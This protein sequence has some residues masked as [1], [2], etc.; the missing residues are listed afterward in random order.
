[1]TQE[2]L[3][4][5]QENNEDLDDEQVTKPKLRWLPLESNPDVLNKIIHENG[6]DPQ[7]S[8]T[9][10][11]GFDEESLS[12]IPKPVSAMIFLFPGTKN[13]QTFLEKEEAHLK[14]HEQNISPNLIYFKQTIS[15]ACG[16]MAL[17]HSLANNEHLVGSGLFTKIIEDTKNMSP[18]ERGEYLEGCPALAELHEYGAKHGQS[19]TPSL[20]ELFT[21]HFICFVQ[22]DDHLYELDG[23]RAFPINHGKSTDFVKDAAKIMR[24]F[25]ERDPNDNEYSALAFTKTA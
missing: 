2:E 1:M 6:V 18:E 7:W 3:M 14:T 22:V 10:V 20:E 24:Q 16:M 8:F 12:L 9:D 4:I 21:N 23:T 25:I 11:L 19:E 17:L 13:Y 5:D 15:N